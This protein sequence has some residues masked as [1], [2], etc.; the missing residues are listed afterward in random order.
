[1]TSPVLNQQPW[2]VSSPAFRLASRTCRYCRATMRL[3]RIE[4][5]RGASRVDIHFFQCDAC[6]HATSEDIARP[7]LR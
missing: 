3:W 7:A 1:M 2:W 6:G 5:K 4:P